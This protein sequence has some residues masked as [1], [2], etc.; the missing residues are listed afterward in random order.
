MAVERRSKKQGPEGRICYFLSQRAAF[1]PLSGKLDRLY[2]GSGAESQCFD[3]RN[4]VTAGGDAVIVHREADIVDTAVLDQCHPRVL[5]AAQPLVGRLAG[6]A[7]RAGAAANMLKPI[8][9]VA[10]RMMRQY[11]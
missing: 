8:T 6:S 5:G 7:A 3:K 9:N 4:L 2:V 10:V 11:A 1:D